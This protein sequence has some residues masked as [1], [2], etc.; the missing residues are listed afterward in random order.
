M[1]GVRAVAAP[2]GRSAR[3]GADVAG[4][5]PRHDALPY[6]ERLEWLYDHLADEHSRLQLVSLVGAS[7]CGPTPGRP[8]SGQVVQ[9]RNP[10]AVDDDSMA[11]R[12]VCGS[13]FPDLH[14]YRVPG[15]HGPIGVRARR[16]DIINTFTIERFAYDHDDVTIR[17]QTGH[18]VIDG[19][20]RYGDTALYFADRVGHGGEVHAIE[21]DV[22]NVTILRENCS[23]NPALGY[24]TIVTVGVVSDHSGDWVSYDADGPLRLLLRP[25]Q[26][27]LPVA[28]SPTVS[29]DDLVTR[30]M[31]ARIDFIKLDVPDVEKALRGARKTI[32]T[33]RP[34][35]A[36]AL[37]HREDEL[38]SIQPRL[39]DVAD[40][41]DLF[42]D[43]AEVGSAGA[44]LFA[45]PHLPRP[46]G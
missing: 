41:Y 18:V 16:N 42:L 37:H 38:V 15:Q 1:D 11:G 29:I 22:R 6:T 36:I 7:I 17:A 43:H 28:K 23:A 4:N 27:E 33:Y 31:I 32:R 5:A 45:R 25:D 3:S 8:G 10:S 19:G 30:E 40:G 13:T 14:L 24:Q 12:R 2:G 46:R 20:S 34:T 26:W 35:L 39:E 9:Q 21:P 44:V